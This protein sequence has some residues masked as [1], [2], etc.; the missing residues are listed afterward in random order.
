MSYEFE[1]PFVLVTSKYQSTFATSVTPLSTAIGG[2]VARCRS[3][4]S[5]PT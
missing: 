3:R 2:T 1:E 5:T 4:T